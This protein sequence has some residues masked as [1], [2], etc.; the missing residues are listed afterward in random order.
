MSEYIYDDKESRGLWFSIEIEQD[1]F[2]VYI[3]DRALNVHFDAEKIGN[4]RFAY[5]HHRNTLQRVAR[6]KFL[7]GAP[8]PIKL[9]VGDFG[10]NVMMIMPRNPGIHVSK[11][12]ILKN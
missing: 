4:R 10:E 1:E 3:T 11:S 9:D 2:L 6:E 7:N 8:R 5:I 12:P